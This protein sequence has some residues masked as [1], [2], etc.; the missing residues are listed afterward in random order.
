MARCESGWAT[1]RLGA[2]NSEAASVSES[3]LGERITIVGVVDDVVQGRT[4][5][6]PIRPEFYVPLDQQQSGAHELALLVRAN[7]N[8]SLIV[9]LV[10]AEIA[11]MDP[12]LAM[13]EVIT[14]DELISRALG[15][16]RL[17]LVSLSGFAGVALLL[18][19]V[20]LYAII[21]FS[22]AQRVRE[23]GIR[24]AMGAQ[25]SDVLALILGEGVR[26]TLI[27]II[28]GTAAA[29][30]LTRFMSTLLFGVN[31][32]DPRTLIGVGIFLAIVALAACL[33]A[34]RRATAIT[35]ISA[36]R[37]P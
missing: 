26:L 4:V 24:M 28:L 31:A 27:G 8:P 17:A 37:E 19:T 23:I 20:G 15:P 32:S 6:L 22:I 13:F 14:G 5:D 30:T 25:R 3:G 16:H 7:A 18:A 12:E 11:K 2:V 1:L 9:P 29:V 35:P 33:V 34:A 21:M 10:R 36:L